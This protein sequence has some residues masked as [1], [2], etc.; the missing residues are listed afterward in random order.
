[1]TKRSGVAPCETCPYRRSVRLAFW[2]ICEYQQLEAA[3]HNLLGA[4]F[5][6]H[7]E[8]KKAP[9]T[10]QPCVGWLLDQRRRGTP[11]IQLRLR[12]HRDAAFLR[13]YNGLRDLGKKLYGSIAEMFLA[14]YP[15]RRWR[16]MQPK[17][18]ARRSTGA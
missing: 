3:D 13:Y 7:G 18:T 16:P 10:R 8:R 2:D 14:N 12:L 6:C 11:S 15:R 17:P 9:K 4:M 1:M 5:D